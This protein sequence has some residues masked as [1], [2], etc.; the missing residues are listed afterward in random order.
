M[1]WVARL[2][3]TVNLRSNTNCKCCFCLVWSFFVCF[4]FIYSFETITEQ[5][6]SLS[7]ISLQ[8]WFTYVRTYVPMHVHRTANNK[9]EIS[10]IWDGPSSSLLP[11]PLACSN[12]SYDSNISVQGSA[13][14][15]VGIVSTTPQTKI[16]YF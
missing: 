2:L 8:I 11:R 15:V 10:R 5:G 12:M 9:R 13:V 4:L 3:K 6:S 1:T 7:T 14:V 16:R